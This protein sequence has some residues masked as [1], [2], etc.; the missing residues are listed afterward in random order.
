MADTYNLKNIKN[1]KY[2][3]FL[4]PQDQIY[5]I[6]SMIYDFNK[7]NWKGENINKK[8]CISKELKTLK[9]EMI[10]NHEEYLCEKYLN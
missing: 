4:L 7:T 6:N 1:K 3:Q 10:V 5:E 8:F 9:K 2:L